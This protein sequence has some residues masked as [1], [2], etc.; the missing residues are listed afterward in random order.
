MKYFVGFVQKL[1]SNQCDGWIRWAGWALR[2]D[3]DKKSQ[4]QQYQQE[5]EQYTCKRRER[6]KTQTFLFN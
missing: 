5:E 4:Q 3:T 6:Y 2:E 1:C